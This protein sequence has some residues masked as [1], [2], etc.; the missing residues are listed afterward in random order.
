MNDEERQPTRVQIVDVKIPLD[1]MIWLL[2]KLTIAAIP[3]AIIVVL[4]V[5]AGI[6]AFGALFR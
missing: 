3:A 4:M 1:S 5:A 6:A 2:V